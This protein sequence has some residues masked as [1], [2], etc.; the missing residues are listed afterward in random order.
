MKRYEA[1]A[2]GD[3]QANKEYWDRETIDGK[4][5]KI[6]FVDNL[7]MRT[8][9]DS[10]TRLAAFRTGKIDVMANINWD[11]LKSLAPI[12]DKIKVI[13]H[14]DYAGEALA[15]RVDAPPFDNQKVRLA[16]NL[17]VDR[18]AISKQIYGGH[19]DFPH[20][21]MDETWEGYFTPPEKMPNESPAFR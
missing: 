9:G 5:Y 18:A 16:L 3:Y 7:V 13:E 12:Q 6:P 19:A 20:L 15:M 10:Q 14:P 8:I 4:P 11:E 17:A 2:F 1:G 21:P